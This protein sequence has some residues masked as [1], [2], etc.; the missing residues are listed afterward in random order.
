M[1]VVSRS[2]T[3]QASAEQPIILP[4][5]PGL[6]IGHETSSCNTDSMARAL[7]VPIPPIVMREHVREPSPIRDDRYVNVSDK[8]RDRSRDRYSNRDRDR[9]R[10][11]YSNRDR[12][13]SRDRYSNRDRDRSWDV[14]R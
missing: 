14:Q 4:P 12:D 9:S 8:D 13:R 10:D 6:G 2:E 11:R 3:V 7:D 1:G 5:V